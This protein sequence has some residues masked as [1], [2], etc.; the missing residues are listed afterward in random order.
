MIIAECI[1]K[2]T[3][4]GSC[5][6]TIEFQH[7]S[8]LIITNHKKEIGI[9]I[10]PPQWLSDAIIKAHNEQEESGVSDDNE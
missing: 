9:S 5:R 2:N 4:G 6:N 3:N 1:C 10:V 8:L 7:A